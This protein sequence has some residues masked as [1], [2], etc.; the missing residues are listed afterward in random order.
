VAQKPEDGK[1]ERKIGH[2]QDGK[3][4]IKS[5]AFQFLFSKKPRF[6]GMLTKFS[7]T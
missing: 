4:L 2:L 3:Q 1:V 7:G 6:I 5:A